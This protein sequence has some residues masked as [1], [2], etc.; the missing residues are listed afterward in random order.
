MDRPEVCLAQRLVFRRKLTPPVDVL[1]LLQIYADFE[2]IRFPRGIN[3][4][5]IC[6]DLKVP[7]KRPRVF[8]NSTKIERRKRFS[9]AHEL[10]HVLIPWHTGSIVDIARESQFFDGDYWL[11][12]A[13][14][15]RFASEVLMPTD[16]VVQTIQR[17]QSPS[18]A[19]EIVYSDA[20]VSWSA[21]LLKVNKNL[22]TGFV[23]ADLDLSGIV[24]SSGRSIG[25]FAVNP[26]R[27]ERIDLENYYKNYKDIWMVVRGEK[28][29]VWWSLPNA[30]DL[31]TCD[32][33]QDWRVVFDE[34]YTNI[35][36]PEQGRDKLK[37]IITAIISSANSRTKGVDRAGKVAAA[38]QSLENRA[39][40]DRSI[41]DFIMH[42]K[43]YEFL[44][45]RVEQHVA[46]IAD[47]EL[48]PSEWPK[49]SEAT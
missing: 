45:L 13:E 14:A 7:G 8:L 48:S 29:Y 1:S 3:V 31:P 26:P 21:A 5:G 42:D 34:I 28:R 41:R 6:L 33:N 12:E 19:I 18:K 16:W 24:S 30:V 32:L 4:D 36:A 10:G 17:N 2:E 39:R 22:P 40:D 27:G 38:L 11:S 37:N 44:S 23:Y 43:F 49:P 47:H 9:V 35:P 46:K 25:T 15:N 20:H